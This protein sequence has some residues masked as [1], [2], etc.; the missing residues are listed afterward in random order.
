SHFYETPARAYCCVSS[1][2]WPWAEH[3]SGAQCSGV[4][5]RRGFGRRETG[6]SEP[7][8]RAPRGG[9]CDPGEG[10]PPRLSAAADDLLRIWGARDH[11]RSRQL[12]GEAVADTNA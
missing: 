6:C 12:L 3:F 2:A 10:V 5:K 7:L 9:G 8:E 4:P 1:A 11:G